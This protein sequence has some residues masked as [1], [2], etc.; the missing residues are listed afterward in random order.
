[1]AQTTTTAQTNYYEILEIPSDA[2]EREIKRAYYRLAREQHPDKAASPE[3]LRQFEER[4][5]QVSAAYNTLKDP[6]KREA[7]D[8]RLKSESAQKAAAPRKPATAAVLT[9]ARTASTGDPARRDGTQRSPQLGITPEKTLIA[10][11]AYAKGMQLFNEGNFLKAIDFF[12]AAIQNNDSEANYHARL[13]MSLIEAR[14]S[15]TRALDAAQKAIDLDPYNLEHKFSLAYIFECIGS[16]SN[17]RKTYEDILR[18][19]AGNQRAQS[20]IVM[21]NKRKSIFSAAG[22]AGLKEQFQKIMNRFRKR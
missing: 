12:E 5:A 3:E 10:Q 15:A 1:M 19:D 11:K 8:A 14:K 21:L 17:A 9:A 22:Q 2:D 7:Y 16:K 13:A 20:G 18:W 4:F 6:A